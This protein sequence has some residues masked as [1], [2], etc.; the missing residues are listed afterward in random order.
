MPHLPRMAV[1]VIA[2]AVTACS[3]PV[4]PGPT[5]VIR[6]GDIV[7][8]TGTIRFYSLEGGFFAIRGD[9]QVTYDPLNLQDDFKRDG[10]RVRFRARIRSDMG[11]VHMVGPIVELLEIA[12]E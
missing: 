10:L 11:G 9:D 1:F 3:S 12:R 7:S 4:R 5:G 2:V 8:G 6:N